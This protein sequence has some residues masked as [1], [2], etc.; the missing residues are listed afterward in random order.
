M[1]NREPLQTLSAAFGTGIAV[2]PGLIVLP[3]QVRL[4]D[5]PAVHACRNAA[6][7]ARPNRGASH[8]GLARTLARI[9]SRN[10]ARPWG[11]RAHSIAIA[12]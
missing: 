5:H 9:V 11:S 1:V 7:R 10:A 2:A 6:P 3:A 8:N 12:M 4:N